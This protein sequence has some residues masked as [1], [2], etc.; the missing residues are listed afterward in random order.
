MYL[1]LRY[2]YNLPKACA[3]HANMMNIKYEI[4]VNKFPVI[5][6]V[7]DNDAHRISNR[8][9]TWVVLTL[10]ALATE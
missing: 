3:R 4:N 9:N 5:Q 6:A 2:A 10:S 1:L 8:I 7:G